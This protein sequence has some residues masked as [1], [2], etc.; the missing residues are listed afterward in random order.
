MNISFSPTNHD[1]NKYT[2]IITDLLKDGD[3]QSFSLN[4]LLTD[5]KI[6]KTVKIVHLN[7]FE[8]LFKQRT[9]DKLIEFITKAS[10]F[11][12]L[13]MTKKKI[14]W[15]M[16]N[17]ASHEAKLLYLERLLFKSLIYYSDKIVVHSK[18]S[19]DILAPYGHKVISKIVYIPHPDYIDVYQNDETLMENTLNDEKKLNLLFIGAVRPYKNIELLIEVVKQLPDDVK[20]T[21]VGKPL[22]DT[23]KKSL[24][25]LAKGKKNIELQL[26]FVPDNEITSYIHE[27]DLL[28]LPYEKASSLN[29]GTVILAFSNRKSVICPEIGT[30]TDIHDKSCLLSYDY[31]NEDEHYHHLLEK[32]KQAINLKR[33]NS[34]IFY[35]WG[36]QMYAYIR[37]SNNKHNVVKSLIEIYSSLSNQ[38]ASKAKTMA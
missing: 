14:I 22:N 17:K 29:S 38:Q 4:A 8:S 21:V 34:D 9:L 6:F 5:Y 23:Y 27:N 3:I 1:T 19:I 18:A 12:F 31:S 28:V 25:K 20:L 15:T 26:E 30:I 35:Y 13:L 33:E 2:K 37:R 36:N 11:L 24:L 7:W 10:I 16:H 32:I